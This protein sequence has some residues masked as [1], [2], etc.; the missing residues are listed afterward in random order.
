MGNGCLLLSLANSDKQTR[1]DQS[2][3]LRL[4]QLGSP[5]LYLDLNGYAQIGQPHNKA[6]HRFAVSARPGE[7][8]HHRNLDRLDNTLANLDVLYT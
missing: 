1:V 8:V 6:L 5:P 4:A 2:T 7:E 3:A